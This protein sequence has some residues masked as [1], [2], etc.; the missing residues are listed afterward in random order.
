MAGP[1]RN[2]MK[3]L[4]TGS[5]GFLASSLIPL[6]KSRGHKVIG[7]DR[8]NETISDEFICHDLLKPLT[9]TDLAFDVCI[10][11]ASAV[12]GFLFNATQSNLISSEIQILR[13]L[14]IAMT[15]T[16]AKDFIFTSSMNVFEMSPPKEGP[17]NDFSQKTSYAQAKAQ[18]ELFI[19]NHFKNFKIIRPTNFF[20]PDQP[21]VSSS[22]GFSHVIPD[23]IYKLQTE[24]RLEVLGDG[25][26]IR[27]F[28]HLSDVSEFIFLL[29]ST[30]RSDYFNI[31]SE[32]FISIHDLALRLMKFLGIQKE[33]IFRPE[34]MR[35]EPLSLPNF[36]LESAHGLEWRCK[37]SDL[38][39]GLSMGPKSQV[40]S[41]TDTALTQRL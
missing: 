2:R 40:S 1:E 24:S 15:R 30:N 36:S 23:L 3:I 41:Q 34:Y 6:L 25:S 35:Y 39:L 26:Q 29:L 19:S 20:G 38:N 13:N 28:I 7:L 31:R 11:L 17:L 32:I 5:A 9:I 16:K 18:A 27:N 12:G 8:K 4:V 21:R 33:I 37:V 22:I 14:K 10:H